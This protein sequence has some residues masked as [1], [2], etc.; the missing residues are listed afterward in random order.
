MNTRGMTVA[1]AAAPVGSGRKHPR[2]TLSVAVMTAGPGPR[3]AA[4]LELLR[5]LA[6][7]IIVAVDD[8]APAEVREDVATVADRVIVYPFLEPVDRPLPWLF[9]ECSCDWMLALDDDEVPS[10]ALLEVLRDLLDDDR[11]VHYSLSRRWLYPDTSTCLDEP[12]W[13][14]DYQPRLFRTDPRLIRFSDDLHRPIILRGPGR[15]VRE[16]VWHLDTAL[17]TYEERRAKADRY[18]VQRAGLRAGG[19]SLNYGFYLPES[20]PGAPLAPVP[21]EDRTLLDLLLAAERPAGVARAK[22][23]PVT[24]A[25]IDAHWPA[26]RSVQS[27][28]LHL[29]A[30][31]P[32]FAAGEE[33]AVEVLVRNTS[34]ETWQWGRASL[35]TMRCA[36]WWEGG[37]RTSAVWTPL[38]APVA[39]GEELAV[40]VHV[41]APERPGVHRLLLD[42]VHEDV[43]WLEIDATCLVEVRPRRRVAFVDA[44]PETIRAT[45]AADPDVEPVVIGGGFGYPAAPSP[46]AFLLAETRWFRL[47]LPIRAA[48]LLLAAHSATA[49]PHGARE[50]LD[51]LPTCDRVLVGPSGATTRREQWVRALTIAAARLRRV[52]V[53]RTQ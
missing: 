33:R 19:R 18:E 12:P 21:S 50:F 2:A 43:R 53:T 46:A 42:L 34:T 6:Q 45:L 22:P 32:S 47:A 28:E 14:P 10:V 39:P 23:E 13:H 9:H 7:E 15:V 29:A 3:V 8:R 16:P 1:P 49:L 52:P 4:T 27:G 24:R 26:H 11:I 40:P 51:L 37:D 35:P 36:T 31:P 30:D 38:P 17:R 44:R 5:P 48:R 41:R 25:E 20:R